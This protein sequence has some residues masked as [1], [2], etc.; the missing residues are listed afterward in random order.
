METQW[1]LP[2]MTSEHDVV[3]T[4]TLKNVTYGWVISNQEVL[5]RYRKHSIRYIFPDADLVLF[6]PTINGFGSTGCDMDISMI[7][8]SSNDFNSEE[9]KAIIMTLSQHLQNNKMISD[10]RPITAAKVPI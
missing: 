2:L 7:L 8:S 6:G 5:W 9:K 10:I 4:K 1:Y 3:L